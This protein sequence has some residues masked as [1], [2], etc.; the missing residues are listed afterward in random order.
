MENGNEATKTE[1]SNDA[2]SE[3]VKLAETPVKPEADK[4]EPEKPESEKPEAEQPKNGEDKEVKEDKENVEGPEVTPQLLEKIKKQ[5]EFYFGDVNMQRDKFLIEQ[6]KLSEGW[7]PLEV[8]LKFKMLASMTQDTP[9]IVKALE[10]SELIETSEDKTKIRRSLDHPLPVYDEEYRKAQEARTVYAKGFPLQGLAMDQ[11]KTFFEPFEPIENIY[12]RKYADK[13]KKMHFKGSVFVQFK[14]LDAAKIFMEKDSVKYE[15]TVLIRRWAA[16]YNAEK[17]KEREEKRQKKADQK[18]KKNPDQKQDKS[19]TEPEKEEKEAF[20]LPK[21]SV[22]YFSGLENATREDIRDALT[23]L[24]AQIAY[25]DYTRG[26]ESGHVRLAKENEAKTVFEKLEEGKIKLGEKEVS[27]RVLEGD[28]EAEYLARMER[29][30]ADL[31]KERNKSG[32]KFKGGKKGG[33]Q[34]GRFQ[35]GQKRKGGDGGYEGGRKR[36]A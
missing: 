10:A 13:E 19:A 22:L 3:E 8:M 7:I 21:G 11:L 12:M 23:K 18:D 24:D 5:V 33:K 36:R 16:E 4:P 35:R 34:G 2:K 15:E 14:T 6:T 27:V 25:V 20:S 1:E 31:R 29:E 9:T 28:E 26:N 30:L 17:Q 32:N